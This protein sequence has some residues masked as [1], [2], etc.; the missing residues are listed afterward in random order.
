MTWDVKSSE[1]DLGPGVAA[2]LRTRTG[3]EGRSISK[4]I[5]CGLSNEKRK[6][7]VG[8]REG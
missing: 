2:R 5:L 8:R 3:V 1:R 4:K 6:L 7:G